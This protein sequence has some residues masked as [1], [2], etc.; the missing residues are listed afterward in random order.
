MKLHW[1]LDEHSLLQTLCTQ[2]CSITM[3]FNGNTRLNTLHWTNCVNDND[4]FPSEQL[5]KLVQSVSFCWN[6]TKNMSILSTWPC[7]VQAVENYEL[8]KGGPLFPAYLHTAGLCNGRFPNL[9]EFMCLFVVV[10]FLEHHISCHCSYY[11]CSSQH[12]VLCHGVWNV[13]FAT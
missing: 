1:R 7:F 3:W 13:F 10:F 4:A 9:Y 5:V 2:F 11:V 6:K 12:N 8:V